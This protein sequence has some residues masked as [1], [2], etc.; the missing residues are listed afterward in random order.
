MKTTFKSNPATVGELWFGFLYYYAFEFKWGDH[1]VCIRK[2]SLET[3]PLTCFTKKWTN[4]HFCIE[5]PFE[6][7]HNL[8]TGVSKQMAL[9]ILQI[10]VNAYKFFSNNL[11]ETDLPNEINILGYLNRQKLQIGK[12]PPTDRLCHHCGHIGHFKNNCPK[13]LEQQQRR[14]GEA[15]QNRNQALESYQ[16]RA[17]QQ[18]SNWNHQKPTYNQNN[19]QVSY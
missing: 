6:L 11:P 2:S 15:M 16:N 8:G 13:M 7:S 18:F 12:R 1:V 4:K 9:Y 5:D 3:E 19:H 14:T 17:Q 10:F